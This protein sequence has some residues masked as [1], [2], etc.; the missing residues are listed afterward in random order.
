[1]VP[2]IP[3]SREDRKLHAE[4]LMLTHWNIEWSNFENKL[5]NLRKPGLTLPPGSKLPRSTWC[6]LNRLLTGHG[7]T[8]ERLHQW[9][10]KDSPSCDCGAAIQSNYHIVEECPSRRLP[11]GMD[12]LSKGEDIQK[13]LE[14]LDIKL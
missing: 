13:W 8:A 9:G 14:E 6:Q 12:R 2:V 4:N 5:V 3:E 1:M 10:L 7:R 11:G